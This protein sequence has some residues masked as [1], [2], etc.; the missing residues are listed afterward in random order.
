MKSESTIRPKSYSVEN[1][2]GIAEVVLCENIKKQTHIDPETEETSIFY[3]YDEY[4]MNVP[5]RDNL[6]KEIRT[7]RAAWLAAAIKEEEKTLDESIQIN[8]K[9]KQLQQVRADVDYIAMM[10]NVELE[11]TEGD[12]NE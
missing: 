2:G 4:R 8:D 11:E 1:C 12:E 7:N 5:Y 6:L 9:E 3:T 10:C